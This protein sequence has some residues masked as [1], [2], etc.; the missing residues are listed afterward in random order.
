MTKKQQ[1]VTGQLFSVIGCKNSLFKFQFTPKGGIITKSPNYK[2]TEYI[3]VVGE[4]TEHGF[5][6][7]YRGG[8]FQDMAKS[9]LFYNCIT[10][11][12]GGET[13]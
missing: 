1:L 2:H 11:Q 10:F 3:C 4:I 9:Q 8:P 6:Y 13:K 7:A 5:H 12:E